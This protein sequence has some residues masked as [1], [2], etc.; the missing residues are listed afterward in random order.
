MAL[1]LGSGE[2]VSEREQLLAAARAVALALARD[3]IRTTTLGRERAILRLLGVDGLDREG[4][5]LAAEVV[6]RFVSGDP[7][8]LAV[9]IGL[10]FAAALLEYETT[11]QLLALDVAAGTIDLAL[12]AE[13]LETPE[14]LA[15]ATDHLAS[16]LAGAIDQVDAN[17]VARREL[18]DVLGDVDPPRIGTSLRSPEI[19]GAERDATALV[20][21]GLDVLLVEVPVI[22]ELATRLG[23]LGQ[24]TGWRPRD[25]AAED[26]PV[27][28]G[29]QRGL[30]RLRAALDEA[31][32]ARGAYVRL[33][34][35][36]NALAG[37]EAAVVAALERVDILD[38]DPMTDIVVTGVDPQR[39]LMDFAFAV[40]VARRAG[41][42]VL[43]DAGPL[44]VAPDLSTGLNADSATRSGRALALQ[45]IA[46]TLATEE[47]LPA[48][49]LLIGVIP[50]WLTGEPDS[51]PR[52][53]AE[54][55]LRRALLAAHPMAFVEPADEVS[56]EWPAIVAAIQPG[57]G[58]DL[59]LRRAP[60]STDTAIRDAAEARSA[61]EVARDLE[62]SLSARHLEGVARDHAK[63][64]LAA[65]IATV[66]RIQED[67]WVGITGTATT[68]G[69]EAPMGAWGSLG[70]ESLAPASNASDIVER[71]LA[72]GNA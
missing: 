25:L 36:P 65:A 27:P 15:A 39:A 56:A 47:G 28:A 44:V 5:P 13:L 46:A 49:Q 7:G 32:A 37:P 31:A 11:P 67:G 29:S 68:T 63:R 72:E 21:G 6:D 43:L 71:A 18:L 26:G 66:R 1:S 61:S 35:A 53:A 24:V 10:P 22:R 60:G 8:R 9:G 57:K 64:A 33:I 69:A 59:I 54:V 12:E 42:A 2:L 14:R 58:V 45:L 52:A 19:E 40:R 51:A 17:R 38:L 16:L 23:L 20:A 62:S 55:A 3:A 50:G 70:A 4:R 48:D 41:V 34:I 30:A